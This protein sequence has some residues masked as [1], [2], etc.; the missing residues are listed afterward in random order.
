MT[1]YLAMDSNTDFQ[2]VLGDLRAELDALD[3]RLV[4]LLKE[5]A[6]V[7]SQVIQQKAEHGLGPVDRK[8]E[9]EML[10]RIEKQA[11]SVGLD[12]QIASRILKAVIEAFTEL[13][14]KTLDP[15]P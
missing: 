6:D 7:I 10:S 4:I 1:P 5:R 15:G 9:R 13:E 12:P 14:A 3:G 8:R 11:S 2:L